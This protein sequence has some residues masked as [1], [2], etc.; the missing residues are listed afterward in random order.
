[1]ETKIQFERVGIGEV[2]KRH[3]LKVPSNQREYAWEEEHVKALLT[4]IAGSMHKDVYFLGIIVLMTTPK[5]LLE[6]ADGQQRLAT[7]TMMLAA[8]RDI[9]LGMNV[10]F[11]AD[12]I[13]RE[14]LFTSDI[15]AREHISKLTLNDDDNQFFCSK[16]LA[17]PDKRGKLVATRRSHILLEE[18]FQ[19]L[20]KYFSDLKSLVG[21]TGYVAALLRWR[22][23]ILEN[24]TVITMPGSDDL[25]A[26]DKFETL[27][28][29][30]LKTSQADLVKNHLFKE[31][32]NRRAEAQSRWSSM[33]G[34]IESIGDDDLIIDFLRHVCNLLYGQ[35][36]K[37][38]VF[39][40]IKSGNKGSGEA[41]GFLALLGVL[42]EDYA[43]I[44]NPDHPKWTAY[45]PNIRLA[46]KSLN[47]IGVSQ[48]R[49]MLLG[50]AR[51][52]EPKRAAK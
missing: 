4:D 5:G 39:E 19:T 24:A 27:K 44:L 22:K 17:R 30:G 2:I 35:T 46:I 15:E 3:R 36:R 50:T 12:S 26:F 48:I 52:F 7:S 29:R 37:Q 8:I 25:D 6:V 51:H 45:P 1:M 31:A 16:I 13:E 41:I 18:A 38:D 21:E 42:A 34:A 33:R 40:K 49:P 23:Y 10:E 9:F 32:G 43:A 28:D 20:R 47:L 14:F 11:G